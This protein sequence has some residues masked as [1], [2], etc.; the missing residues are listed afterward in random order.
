MRKQRM[1]KWWRGEGKK[2]CGMADHQK[3]HVGSMGLSRESSWT[4]FVAYTRLDAQV[5]RRWQ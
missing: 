4:A 1:S 2:E 3:R 5:K